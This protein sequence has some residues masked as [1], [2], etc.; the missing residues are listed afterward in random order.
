MEGKSDSLPGKALG[1]MLAGPLAIMAI[2]SCSCSPEIPFRGIIGTDVSPPGF[3]GI[4]AVAADRV[5]L[6]F[7]ENVSVV[8]LRFDPPVQAVSMEALPSDDGSALVSVSL[9]SPIGAGTRCVVDAV[10]QDADGNSLTVLAP[11]L[12]RN[13]DMPRLRINEARTEYSRPK[14]EF[15]EILVTGAGNLGAVGLYSASADFA[16]P[17]FVFPPVEVRAGDYLLVH[18]RTLEAQE[19]DETG[20]PDESDGYE[21]SPSARD[22]W[23]P[24]SEER[25]RKTDA[26]MLADQ[27]GAVLDA[28]LLSETADGAWA[29]EGVAEAARVLADGG[30]WRTIETEGILPR[31]AVPSAGCTPTRSVCRIEG[32]DD[33]DRADDWFVCAT[34]CATPGKPNRNERYDAASASARKTKKK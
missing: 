17:M 31:D 20:F 3:R 30:A 19:T 15:V 13:D 25:L 8:S 12:G 22:F 9:G 26:L 11:F 2:L 4:R 33:A 14:V 28:L 32:E 7:T 6:R 5:E 29:G 34:G 23:V 21:S 27:D 1:F 18:L 16:S 10:V 24:G